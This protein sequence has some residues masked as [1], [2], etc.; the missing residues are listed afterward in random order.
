MKTGLALG[1]LLVAQTCFTTWFQAQAPSLVGRWAVTVTFTDT[2]RRTLRLDAQAAGTGSLLVQD[3]RSNMVEP[4]EPAAAKWTQGDEQRVTFS[5]PVEFP[6]GNV[7]RLAGTLL[8]KGKFDAENS[9]VGEVALFPPEQDPQD[10][11]AV[12]SRTG[13]FKATRITTTN[14]SR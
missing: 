8:C 1:V 5:G 9:I 11:Q 4:A 10:P 14:T 3:P 12:P 6:I 13:T 7:G 2:S